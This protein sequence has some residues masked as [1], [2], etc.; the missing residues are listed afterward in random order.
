MS[1]LQMESRDVES[2]WLASRTPAQGQGTGSKCHCQVD[3]QLLFLLPGVS[4]TANTAQPGL[5]LRTVQPSDDKGV[6]KRGQVM[7]YQTG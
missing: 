3:Q 5:S 1:I 6:N 2:G 4:H 7:F